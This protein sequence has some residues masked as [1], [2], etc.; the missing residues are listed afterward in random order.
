MNKNKEVVLTWQDYDGMIARC[1]P[2]PNEQDHNKMGLGVSFQRNGKNYR[3]AIKFDKNING[4]DL[5]KLWKKLAQAITYP[6]DPKS[7][8]SEYPKVLL[9]NEI[10]LEDCDV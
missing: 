8:V 5:L 4:D 1:A 6:D 7:K 9:G 3:A 2:D 10:T